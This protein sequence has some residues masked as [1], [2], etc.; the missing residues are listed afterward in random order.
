MLRGKAP[1]ERA[2]IAARLI[3]YHVELVDLS[4]AQI[5]RLTGANPGTVSIALGNAGKRGPRDRTLEHLIK[6]YGPDT[7]MRVVDRIT[8]PTQVAVE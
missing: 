1:G 5:A 6:R 8:A 7:L 3:Q 2:R 4:P